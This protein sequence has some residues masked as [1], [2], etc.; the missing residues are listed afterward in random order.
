MTAAELLGVE[1]DLGSIA[2][3]KLADVIAVDGN[4]LDDVSILQNVNF[5][6][7]EGAIYREP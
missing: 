1:G 6:M 2:T 3:G 4:P 7:K 5:V